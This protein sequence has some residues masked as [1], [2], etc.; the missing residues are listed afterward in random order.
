[1]L[2]K[3]I[4][5]FEKR[6][7][8]FIFGVIFGFTIFAYKIQ[9]GIT[10]EAKKTIKEC[11]YD[12]TWKVVDGRVLGYCNQVIQ[13]PETEIIGYVKEEIEDTI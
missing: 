12:W 10:P 3:L 2:E 4:C 13:M 1:M 11:E 5:F 6:L 8:T 9:E 7:L